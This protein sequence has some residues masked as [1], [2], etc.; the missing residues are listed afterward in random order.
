ME[1]F[2]NDTASWLTKLEESLMNCAQTETCEG[3][4]KVKVSH[5]LSVSLYLSIVTLIL[6]LFVDYNKNVTS[7]LLPILATNQL[8]H[9]IGDSKVT[10]GE[11]NEGGKKPKMIIIKM[12]SMH[13][14][15]QRLYLLI[16]NTYF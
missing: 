11:L 9:D 12:E 1:K 6:L 3:L 14:P 13:W 15:A 8:I 5:K 10:Y 2:I 4:K 7:V 16:Y